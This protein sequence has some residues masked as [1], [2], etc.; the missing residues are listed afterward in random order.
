MCFLAEVLK[1]SLE[2]MLCYSRG[3]M[4]Q[5]D[6]YCFKP[7]R[8]NG[9]D[10]RVKMWRIFLSS[11]L[12]PHLTKLHVPFTFFR[13]KT[14]IQECLMLLENIGARCPGLRLLK[15]KSELMF[16]KPDICLQATFFRRV[17]PQLA[18]LQV[19]CI[20]FFF[21]GDWALEQFAQHGT[22]LV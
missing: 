21:S 9:V 7:I 19:A 12:H 4:S 20:R 8:R 10:T 16:D 1:S 13:K 6:R 5:I 11:L 22:N 14:E 18:N 15:A 3:M 2:R 17:L